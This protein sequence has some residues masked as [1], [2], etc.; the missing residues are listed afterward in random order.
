M[1][2]V[3]SVIPAKWRGVGIQLVLPQGILDSIQHKYAGKPEEN[4]LSFEMVFYTW[5]NQA[6]R[7]FTWETIVDVLK[8]PAVG[9]NRLADELY[10]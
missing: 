6:Q 8:V 4:N 9:E 7:P 1:S 2:D 3:A 10:Y 5:K